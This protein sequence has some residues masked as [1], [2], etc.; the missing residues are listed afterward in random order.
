MEDLK[1]KLIANKF[2]VILVSALI[3]L[4]VGGLL[5]FKT[6][7]SKNAAAVPLQEVDLAFEADGPYALLLPRRDGNAVDLNIKRV[8]SYDSISYELSYQSKI[9]NNTGEF[10]TEALKKNK[11]AVSED[12]EQ[13]SD[14]IDRGVTGTIKT[15][16]SKNEYS[17]EILFGTCSKGDTMSLLH[18]V[19]DKGV[20]NGVL[21][22]RIQDDNLVNKM[23]TTW[24]MQKPD[25]ALGVITSA[26]TH[27]TYKTPASKTELVATGYTIVNDLTGVPKLPEGKQV[28]G[29][30]YALNVPTARTLSPGD[31]TLELAEDPPAEAKIAR[32]NESKNEWEMLNTK[33]PS[34]STLSAPAAGAGIFAVLV[35][36]STK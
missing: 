11:K 10:A 12:G 20:E 15:S 36:S 25:V 21:I 2:T 7:T 17:Q 14:S 9:D 4:I 26:D 24:H 29:K 6:I 13:S 28:L 23:T 22:L 33:A 31:V 19:F 18:C 30:V 1:K 3:L 16:G 5:L 27:F 8:S 35:N 34:G 32:Y